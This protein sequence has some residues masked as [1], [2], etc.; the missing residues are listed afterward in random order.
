[1]EFGDGSVL[2]IDNWSGSP[3]RWDKLLKNL[4]AP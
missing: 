3:K 2:Q 4:Q 1:M